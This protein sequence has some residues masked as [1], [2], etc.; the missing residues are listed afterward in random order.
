MANRFYSQD[1][2]RAARVNDLF[3]RIAPRYDL[4]ND[5]QSFGLHRR[6]KRRVVRLAAVQSGD[7]AL[8]LCC[9]TGDIAF[10]LGNAGAEVVGLDFTQAMLDVANDRRSKLDSAAQQ[11]TTFIRGDAQQISFPDNSFDVVTVGY[12]LRNLSSWETGLCEMNRVAKPGGR[13]LV[14]EFGKPDNALWRWCYFTYL[15]MFVP[16]LGWVF[17]RNAAAYAYILE[18][19]KHYPAQ[20][21]IAEKMK[22]LGMQ[23]VQIVNLLGGVMSINYGEKPAAASN[24][25]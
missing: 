23:N 11:R 17:C 21:G 6:W 8:D 4:I 13:L 12:G 3:R 20:R 24:Q 15:K 18:S 10:A 14:L 25:H 7:R 9:G 22:K 19:L 16:V 2:Q 1:E 5:L